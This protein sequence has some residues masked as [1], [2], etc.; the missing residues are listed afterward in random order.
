VGEQIGVVVNQIIVFAILMAVGFIAAKARVFTNDVLDALSRIIVKVILPLLIFTIVAGSGVKVEDFLASGNFAIATIC[1]FILLFLT[2]TAVSKLCKLE[3][4]TANVFIALTTFGNMGF[5]GI[6]LIQSIYGGSAGS[7]CISVYAL[8]DMALLWT[9]GVYLCSKHEK[10]SNRLSAVKNMINP[11]TV[12]LVIAIIIVFFKIPVPALLMNTIEGIGNTS[13]YLTLMY[14]GGCLACVSVKGL[15]KKPSIYILTALK[16][17]IIPIVVYYFLGY[18]L[19]QPSRTIL[20]L[21][22]GLPSMTTVAMVAKIYRSDDVFATETIFVS[23][24]ACLIT[25]PVVSIITSLM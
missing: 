15:I 11:T 24:L 25:I 7:I 8:I 13:K 18:L 19:T 2:G 1:C 5:V 4:K 20:T 21:I 6:P 16:M 3:G 23:T 10:N 17:L 12:A 22:V 14:L 9:L